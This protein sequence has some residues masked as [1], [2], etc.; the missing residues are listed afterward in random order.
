MTEP[1]NPVIEQS[2]R[3]KK[4]AKKK[5]Y[6]DLEDAWMEFVEN[7]STDLNV[8]VPTLQVLVRQEEAG[9]AE[10]LFWF[11]LSARTENGGE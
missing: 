6:D 3:L 7:E 8:F 11:L 4:L 1:E 9:R 2:T 5:R 10:S